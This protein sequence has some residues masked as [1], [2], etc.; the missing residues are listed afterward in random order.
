MTKSIP[1]SKKPRKPHTPEFR[2]EVLKLAERIG[3][4]GCL[5]FE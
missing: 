3:V 4:V 1:T 2:E 5:F